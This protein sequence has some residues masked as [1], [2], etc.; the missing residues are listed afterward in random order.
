LGIG[1]FEWEHEPQVLRATLE[2]RAQIP[3]SNQSTSDVVLGPHLVKS[4]RD[5]AVHSLPSDSIPAISFEVSSGAFPF[6]DVDLF[7]YVASGVSGERLFRGKLDTGAR[8]CL[9][10]ERVA[11][12]FG[13][14]RIDSSKWVTLNDIGQNEVRTI[15]EI[16]I[17][18]RLRYGQ[19][20]M[21]APFHVVPDRFVRGRFDALLP[22]KLIKRMSLFKN[23]KA[24]E[25]EQIVQHLKAQRKLGHRPG[26]AYG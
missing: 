8:I 9:I 7:G 20:W 24:E 21:N 15:G 11:S 1:A 17:A 26:S 16:M 22:D 3:L 12:G 13:T 25:K 14:D 2:D 6:P 4:D 23:Q 10:A 18:V 19:K 5:V